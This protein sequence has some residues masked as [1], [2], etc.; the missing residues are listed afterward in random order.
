MNVDGRYLAG[1]TVFAAVVEAG[2]FARAAEGLG[3]S[4]SGVSRAISRLE[5]RLG[6]R[7]LD[8][9]TRSTYLTDEG[10][11]FL[12]E[13]RPHL[14]ALEDAAVAASNGVKA[15]SGRL[16]V[17]VDPYF[18]RIALSKHIQ[19]FLGQ[20]PDLYL[21]LIDRHEVGDLVA[22]GF[23]M[24]VRFGEPPGESLIA[25][26]L[27]E[28]RVITVASPHYIARHGRPGQPRELE[29]H[30]KI[31]FLD[32][33]AQRPFGWEFRRGAEV[34]EIP[35]TGVLLVSDVGAM[36]N[37]AIVGAGVAQIIDVGVSS[38]LEERLLI[39][40]FPDWPDERFPLYALFPS[41]RHVPAKVSA[42]ADFC[43]TVS[44]SDL[45]A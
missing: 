33:V 39:D 35:H 9:T 32:P 28:A 22:D 38:L 10:R 44:R 14:E 18:S 20:Y 6:L 3:L 5:S 41:R 24:A 23:D 45:F 13:I 2:T 8:R 17:N 42:F 16:R 36:L 4:A 37:A 19:H 30:R 1:L 12:E 34:V 26:K 25:V 29:H 31:L 40:L 43:R 15:V 27:I 21:E 7:L 11:R